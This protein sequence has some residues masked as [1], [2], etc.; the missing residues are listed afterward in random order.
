MLSKHSYTLTLF[1]R[2]KQITKNHKIIVFMCL[3]CINNYKKNM[4]FKN[5]FV[6]ISLKMNFK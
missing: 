6:Q 4:Y 1:K 3:L 2:V 5:C